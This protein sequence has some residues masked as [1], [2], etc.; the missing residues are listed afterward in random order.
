MKL[1]V[2]RK[3]YGGFGVVL[4]LLAAVAFVGYSSLNTA[5]DDAET[6]DN[7]HFAQYQASASLRMNLAQAAQNARTAVLQSEAAKIEAAIRRP[8]RTSPPRPK[9]SAR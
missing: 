1:T 9:T 7:E 3:L 8:S 6:V 5:R 2:A 4:V